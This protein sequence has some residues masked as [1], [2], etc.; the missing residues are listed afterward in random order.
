M[1]K[2]NGPGSGNPEH[3]GDC[4]KVRRMQK[5]PPIFR[6]PKGCQD[7]RIEKYQMCWA[8]CQ[9]AKPKK[10]GCRDPNEPWRLL[11]NPK[12]Q[13]KDNRQTTKRDIESFDFDQPAFFDDADIRHPDKGRDH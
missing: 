2:R 4:S 12:T 13:P 11:L 1:Q 9:E 10:N 8:L 7:D 3:N 6:L 5:N